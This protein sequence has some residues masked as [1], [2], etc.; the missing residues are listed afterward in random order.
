MTVANETEDAPPSRTAQ[1]EHDRAAEVTLNRE[2]PRREDGQ[3]EQEQDQEL[4]KISEKGARKR[5]F[6][7]LLAYLEQDVVKTGQRRVM[8]GPGGKWVPGTG[9]FKD[10]STVENHI[11]KLMK[12]TAKRQADYLDELGFKVVKITIRP[13]LEEELLGKEHDVV[14]KREHDDHAPEDEKDRKARQQFGCHGGSKDGYGYD[15]RVRSR[16]MMNLTRT[17]RVSFSG[18]APHCGSYVDT[19]ANNCPTGGVRAH[20]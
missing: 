17:T 6:P 11:E 15:V 18:D 2:Q 20:T 12:V 7:A 8:K 3:A 14:E 5:A 13:G 9:V 10:V 4:M 19:E 16:M 1:A